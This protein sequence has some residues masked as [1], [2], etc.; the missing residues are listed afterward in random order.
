MNR[1]YIPSTG[2]GDWQK[3]LADPEL[4]W[5]EGYS[6][7]SLAEC[8]EAANGLPPEISDLFRQD[9]IAP[10]LLFAIPEHQ[11]PLPGAK[12]GASQCDVF[13]LIRA[14][15]R[16]V[17]VAIEG[18]V[19][20]PFG[21]LLGDWLRG[22]SPGKHK[23]LAFVADMLG[24][25]LPLPDDI[26]YQ[27]LHRTAAAIVEARRFNADDAAMIVHSFSPTGKW[28]DAFERFAGLFGIEAELGTRLDI[29]P[30]GRKPFSLGWVAGDQRFLESKG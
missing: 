8:W 14:G 22:A 19:D 1:I 12:R 10:E 28:F 5:R 9:G 2:P 20:E 24:L 17:A 18:K 21:P 26:H 16:T 4:H 3:L 25:A 7:M 27:L 15:D 30:R 23:R 6:A 29:Q 11:V 13:A